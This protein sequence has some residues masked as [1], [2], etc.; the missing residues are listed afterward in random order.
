MGPR[1]LLRSETVDVIDR[2]SRSFK[3][4]AKLG[5]QN[6]WSDGGGAKHA[7]KLTKRADGSDPADPA[8]AD[9]VR[10]DHQVYMFRIRKDDGSVADRPLF[11]LPNWFRPQEARESSWWRGPLELHPPGSRRIKKLLGRHRSGAREQS[12]RR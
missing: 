2:V 12:H 11:A 8:L 5:R 1:V 4:F 7:F 6:I 3:D 10:W 9:F